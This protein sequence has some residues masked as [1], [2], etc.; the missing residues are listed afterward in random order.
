MSM[1]FGG[2]KVKEMYWAGR[3]IKE[4]W[5]EGERVFSGKPVEVMPAMSGTYD[6]RDWLRAKLTEYGENYATVKEIPFEIDAGEATTMRNMFANCYKLVTAPAMDTSQVT[7]TAYLFYQCRSLIEVPPMN[8]AQVTDARNM[9]RECRELTDGNVRLIGKHP[10]VDTSSMI[11]DS[12]LTREPF[13]DSSG[14][15]I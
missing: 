14:R 13:Y 7:N 3:K 4:A 2:K 6:A 15:P 8:T 9:L 10:R 5:Y 1:H 11:Y 12:G